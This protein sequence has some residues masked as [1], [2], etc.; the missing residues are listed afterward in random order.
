MPEASEITQ[1]RPRIRGISAVVCNFN[2]EGYLEECLDSL[3]AQGDQLDE[4]LV[5]DNAST[6]RSL[7]ILA[8]KYPDLLVF[9]L[10]ENGGPCVARNLGMRAAKHRFVLAVDNDA[11]LEPGC[12]ARLRSAL[13]ADRGLSVAQPRSVRDDA[14]EVVHYDGGH[15]HYVGLLALTNFYSDRS[16]AVGEGVVE[17]DA[18]IGISPLVDKRAVLAVGGYDEDFFYLAEDYDLALR[19]RQVGNRLCTVSEAIVRHKG[20][21]AGLSFRGGGYPQRRAYLMSRNRWILLLKCHRFGTLF[22]SLPGLFVYESVWLVFAT[23]EGHLGVHL[24][25]KWDVLKGLRSTLAKRHEVQRRRTVDDRELLVGGPLTLSPSL[26]EKP[27]AR[28]AAGAIDAVLRGWWAI[29]RWFVL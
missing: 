5:V 12:V 10:A 4:I 14:P 1:P 29:A 11:V 17:T 6:D 3:V 20:G 15:F 16:E 26:V 8:E 22:A 24:R 23:L 7:E 9:A 19:L 21:T 28:K 25:G 13:E 18:L 27:L 2:G